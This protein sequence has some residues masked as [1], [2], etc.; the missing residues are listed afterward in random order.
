VLRG[1]GLALGGLAVLLVVRAEVASERA[2][3]VT[4][5]SRSKESGVEISA[6]IDRV[7]LRL[8][9]VEGK[10]RLV[11][12]TVRN[13]TD[14]RVI[15]DASKDSMV[16]VLPGKDGARVEAVLDPAV[17][18][19]ATW[20]KFDEPS[21]K[22]LAYPKFLDKGATAVL[23]VLFPPDR[24]TD[25]PESFEWKIDSTGATIKAVR[26]PPRGD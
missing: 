9:A 15:L 25:V 11:R 24:L 2:A 20:D 18:D 12:L 10:Y 16:A 14:A 4:F 3:S 6:S 21:R 22:A 5:S 7:A 19:A 1:L 26:P 8:T 13:P 23:Y 17:A